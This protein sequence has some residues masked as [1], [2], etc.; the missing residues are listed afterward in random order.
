M[1]KILSIFICTLL[2]SVSVTASAEAS[3]NELITESDSFSLN[4]DSDMLAVLTKKDTVKE[5]N[6]AVKVEKEKPKVNKYTV[7]GNDSLSKIAKQFNTSWVRIWSKN[8]RLTN[9]DVINT[10]S[11]LIIPKAD[12][13]LETRPLPV[14]EPVAR[15]Q[16][17]TLTAPAQS[18]QQRQQTANPVSSSAPQQQRT[19]NITTTV[20]SAGNRYVAGYCTWYAKNRRP[21]LPNNLGNADTWVS[22]A[23]AQGLPTGSTPRVG[24]IGQQGMHVVYVEKVH[25]NGTVTISEMNWKGLYVISTRTVPSSNFRYIY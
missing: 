21:D 10:G 2:L 12:E 22:R 6:V 7:R 14:A 20:S 11:I 8:T 3:S 5:D 13:D 1:T 25:S 17:D 16:V 24:A 19:Q 23:A 9:P 18:Q 4:S 15:E